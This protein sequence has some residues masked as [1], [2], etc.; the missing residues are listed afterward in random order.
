MVSRHQLT[1]SINELWYHVEFTKVQ[2]I[3][4]L[5]RQFQLFW[6][7]DHPKVRELFYPDWD[8]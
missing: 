4:D 1:M 3:D 2:H 8:K 6:N 7:P 5:C